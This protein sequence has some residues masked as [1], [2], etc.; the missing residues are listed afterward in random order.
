MTA[1]SETSKEAELRYARVQAAA[2]CVEGSAEPIARLME[3]H[4]GDRS[5]PE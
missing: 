2:L 3:D 4:Y 1:N 5:Q